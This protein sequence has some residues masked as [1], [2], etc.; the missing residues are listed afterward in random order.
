MNLRELI[1]GALASRGYRLAS[2]RKE[3]CNR[4]LEADLRRL[5]AARP[6]RTIFDVGAFDG[7][8]AEEYRRLFPKAR[9]YSFE[10]NPDQA[11]VLAGKFPEGGAVTVA[12]AAVGAAA[13][14]AVFHLNDFAQTNSLL[15]TAAAV[16]EAGIAVQMETRRRVEVPVV[17]LDGFC[18]ERGIAEIDFL[19]IDVQGAEK[20]VLA[21]AA[22]L[23]AAGA[24]G[25]V[26]AEISF[27][28]YYEGQTEFHEVGA[29]LGAA[30]Y[31]LYNFYNGS[32]N[33]TGQLRFCDALFLS[34]RLA[35]SLEG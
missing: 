4:D 32:V 10:P 3:L 16:A 2:T 35:Q 30:G 5:F 24:V 12:A 19:K 22:G 25:A 14:T 29:L 26:Q 33:P 11:A 9:I 20:G 34:P 17:S 8:Y 23:L 6:P 18:R 21:G 1:N 7:A 15:P 27:A 13:G 28:S 31:R